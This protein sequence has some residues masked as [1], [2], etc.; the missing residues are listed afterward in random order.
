LKSRSFVFVSVA[1]FSRA[2]DLCE[3]GLQGDTACAID[4]EDMMVTER[5][6]RSSS[7]VWVIGGLQSSRVTELLELA[8]HP[9][10][11]ES[12][13][14]TDQKF[15]EFTGFLSTIHREIGNKEL[16]QYTA[17]ISPCD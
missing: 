4:V 1:R 12:R 6:E 17:P 16:R 8:G 9:Q 5:E 2:C 7:C 13:S 3:S 15:P 10:C 11:L 14:L